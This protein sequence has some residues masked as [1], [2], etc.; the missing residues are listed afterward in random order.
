MLWE[1]NIDKI[2]DD[3]CAMSVRWLFQVH[4]WLYPILVL[5]FYHGYVRKDSTKWL[6]QGPWEHFEDATINLVVIENSFV[7]SRV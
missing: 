6:C 3:M 1:E 4:H 5:R 7:I 2:Y